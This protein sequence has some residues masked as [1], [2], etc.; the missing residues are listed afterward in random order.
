MLVPVFH[1]EI[2]MEESIKHFMS[3]C[4]HFVIYC[5]QTPFSQNQHRKERGREGRATVAFIDVEKKGMELEQ[6]KYNV[7]RDTPSLWSSWAAGV[8]SHLEGLA[9]VIGRKEPTAA[10]QRHPGKAPDIKAT[11]IT[12]IYPPLCFSQW[13]CQ[14]WFGPVKGGEEIFREL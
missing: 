8:P 7:P 12:S 4:F 1:V 10:V 9:E 5:P 2:L 3:A 13:P 6:V 14:V 11:S